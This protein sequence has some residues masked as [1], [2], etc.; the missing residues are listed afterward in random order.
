MRAVKRTNRKH[1]VG[2]KRKARATR[3]RRFQVKPKLTVEVGAVLA[4]K[5]LE[6]MKEIEMAIRQKLR[7]VVIKPHS[8]LRTG[9]PGHIF[10]RA[11]HEIPFGRRVRAH[12]VRSIAEIVP[13]C[14]KH[15]AQV[16]IIDEG[17]MFAPELA[18]VVVQL[19][20]VLKCRV[21]FFG[22]DTTWRGR[23]YATTAAVMVIPGAKIFRLKAACI[24]CG[25]N[26]FWS[27]KIRRGRPVSVLD[28]G[29]KTQE[30]G[31][32]E[33]Y[34]PKCRRCWINSTPGGKRLLANGLVGTID[35]ETIFTDPCVPSQFQFGPTWWPATHC[36][37]A[38]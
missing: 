31:G 32:R 36:H 30:V 28:R 14:A 9:D 10:S 26:A 12:V 37:S 29:E 4:G 33:R 1:R 3:R 7:V 27:Q 21:F 15:Q 17:Q 20:T 22:L 25:D 23:S 8:D 6:A 11:K 16:V 2:R 13:W 34:V 24:D 5:T 38:A 35:P 19:L 18:N